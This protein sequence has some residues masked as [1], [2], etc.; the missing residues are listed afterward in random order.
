VKFLDEVD[1]GMRGR[2]TGLSSTLPRLSKFI[3]G[4]Q[5]KTYYA[6][7]AQ[8]K[9][10]KTSLVD[11]LFV[12]GPFIKNPGKK[13]RWIYFSPEVDLLEKMAK[14]VAFFMDY[15]H[16]IYCDSNYIL[17]R[18]DNVLSDEH[19]VF[20]ENIYEN[21]IKELFKKVDFV[22]DRM[23][24][25]GIRRHILEFAKQNGSFLTKSYTKKGEKLE[26][27]ISYEEND[28]DLYTIIIVDHVGLVPQERG[29]SKKENIDKLSSHMVWFRNICR[30]SPVLVSQFNRDLGKVERL[31]FSGNLLQPTLEDF[32][33]TGSLGEDAS[34]VIGLFNPAPY[35]HLQEHL[36]YNLTKIGKNYRSIHVLASRNTEA[37]VSVSVLLEGKT[38]KMKEL[39]RPSS[40]ELERV[41]KYIEKKELK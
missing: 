6:I 5:K 33:D 32:K 26:K 8:A 20:V 16:G 10:G 13:I 28:P 35:K 1:E 36:G 37:N 9:S 29:F 19:R 17:S 2:Y 12:L 15:K 34:M 14:Y 40:L 27:I 38:G 41:Y 21:E 30:F 7:G 11:E 3:N 39:P 22:E 18:G 24:P 4:I 23:N 25:E 31:K